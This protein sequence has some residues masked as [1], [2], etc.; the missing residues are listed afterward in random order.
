MPERPLV[1]PALIAAELSCAL[2]W[3]LM[4]APALGALAPALGIGAVLAVFLPERCPPRS[5]EVLGRPPPRPRGRA[6]GW[7]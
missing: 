7:E 4:G 5:E 1:A 3:A 2:L 6:A